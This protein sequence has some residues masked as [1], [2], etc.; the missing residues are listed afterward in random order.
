MDLLVADGSVD[1]AHSDNPP[2]GGTPQYATDGDPA[3]SA[4]GT[5][6]PSYW[7]NTLMKE[8]V[9]ILTAAGIA[10]DR[11]VTT[12][13]LTGIQVLIQRATGKAAADTGAANAYVVAPVPALVGA[14]GAGFEIAFTPAHDN[15]GASTLNDGLGA[16][17]IVYPDGA[18][19]AAGAIKATGYA[20]CAWSAS[21]GKYVLL[22]SLL[23]NVGGSFGT[24]GYTLFPGT[25]FA[26]AWAAFS[27]ATLS[28]NTN[29]PTGTL[30]DQIGVTL[31]FGFTTRSI[32]MQPMLDIQANGQFV[33]AAPQ[34]RSSGGCTVYVTASAFSAL[35]I[36]GV[37]LA[38]GF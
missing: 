2:V 13:I 10:P 3:T 35:P 29:T 18:A 30:W 31:P 33:F 15:T 32:W 26:A 12:Q 22:T 21:L 4:P 27:L 1:L 23:T 38:F 37:L 36:P 16:V 20:K 9:G 25:P 28:Q 5:V 19:L 6:W 24:T 11:N 17:P 8:L 7:L 14:R 34:G